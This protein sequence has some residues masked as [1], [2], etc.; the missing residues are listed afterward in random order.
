MGLALLLGAVVG[1]LQP[2]HVSSVSSLVDA[3]SCP[4]DGCDIFL[5]G[6]YIEVGIHPHGSYGTAG[7]CPSSNGHITFEAAARQGSWN[8]GLGFVADHDKDRA[9]GSV[10]GAITSFQVAISARMA[11]RRL[12]IRV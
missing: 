9:W 3:G 7:S 4:T 1:L 6:R 11:V 2:T 5:K 10:P 12:V 8:N